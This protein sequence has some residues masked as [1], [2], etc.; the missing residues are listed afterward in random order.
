MGTRV[1]DKCLHAQMSYIEYL[2]EQLKQARHEYDVLLNTKMQQDLDD[3]ENEYGSL[4][5]LSFNHKGYNITVTSNQGKLERICTVTV[6]NTETGH[7]QKLKARDQLVPFF[8]RKTQSLIDDGT[9]QEQEAKELAEENKKSKRGT[10]L[11][12]TSKNLLNKKEL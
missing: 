8:V 6:L 5:N 7:I 9:L 10:S 2:S 3:F 11:L 1:T 12:S 4:D